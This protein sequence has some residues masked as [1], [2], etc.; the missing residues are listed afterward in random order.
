MMLSKSVVRKK[1][2]YHPYSGC[3][4]SFG[5]IMHQYV[6][7]LNILENLKI[8]F[9]AVNSDSHID[10]HYASAI[11]RYQREFSIRY[12]DYVIFAS[13]DDKH[14]IKVGERGTER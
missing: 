5:L 3:G 1:K 2:L 4:S 7:L 12:Q 13:L 14:T 11:F 8:Y 10:A 9:M 6:L